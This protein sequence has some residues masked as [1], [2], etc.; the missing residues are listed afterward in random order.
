MTLFSEKEKQV[1]KFDKEEAKT[2]KYFKDK[3]DV[4]ISTK[5]LEKGLYYLH[6]SLGGKKYTERLVVE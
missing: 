6:I 1:Y 3:E 2:G 5:G 4:E